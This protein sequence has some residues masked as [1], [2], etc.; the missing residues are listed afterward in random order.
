M[1][2][3]RRMAHFATSL[4]V[5]AAGVLTATTLAADAAST[6]PPTVHV[7]VAKNHAVAMTQRLRPGTH[8]YIINSGSSAG[9]QLVEAA[10]GY[11][12]AEAARDVLRGL[13]RGN[14]RAQKRF[15]K[16]ITLLGG[17][18]SRPGHPAVMWVNLPAGDYWALD[19]DA[20]R[21]RAGKFL[22]VHVAGDRVEGGV[23][24]TAVIRAINDSDWASKPA[25]IGHKGR[26]KFRNDSRANHFVIMAK[27]ADGKTMKDFNRWIEKSMR[28][29]DA[30]PPIDSRNELSTGVV[31]PGHAMTL[32]Y[33]LPRG[34]Y[35]LTCF[36][37]DADMHGMP[38][39]FMGM[40]RGIRLT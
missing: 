13:S 31:S 29:V 9:F 33:N 8:K 24:G 28:G 16:N 21:P 1:S 4:G 35:V 37:P 5:A 3:V 10:P 38:H 15:E 12:K 17:A 26:L 2:R 11:T 40:N 25:S 32:K 30:P 19:T 14:T 20:D 18:N 27:L 22:T 39:A 23:R 34:R 6:G 7:Y 36:W